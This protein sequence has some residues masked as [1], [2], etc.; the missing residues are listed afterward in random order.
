MNL[1][2]VMGQFA[3]M[4]GLGN[5]GAEEFTPVCTQAMEEVSRRATG[6]TA[7]GEKALC[8]A[9]AALAFYRWALITAA[10]TPENFSAGDIKIS[11][12]SVHLQAAREMWRQAAAAAAPWLKDEDFLFRRIQE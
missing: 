11:Q 1:E 5:A 6:D 10:G 7:A 9:T 2:E 8:A 3:V 4:T 12:N